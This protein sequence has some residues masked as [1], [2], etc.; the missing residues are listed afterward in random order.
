M[1]KRWTDLHYQFTHTD[2]P[3]PSPTVRAASA[4]AM[5]GRPLHDYANFQY[6]RKQPVSADASGHA[7]Y[8]NYN[9]T[10]AMLANSNSSTATSGSYSLPNLTSPTCPTHPKD[11][12]GYEQLR[13][14]MG[15]DFVFS[16]PEVVPKT[17]QEERDEVY[18]P[19]TPGLAPPKVKTSS[20]SP[21]LK[22]KAADYM[23]SLQKLQCP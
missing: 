6:P 17:R 22:K 11:R 12:Q 21:P 3:S 14:T 7:E 16:E 20:G 9:Q 5:D 1:A 2:M 15:D 13:Q 23:P 8:V 4:D 18:V 19:F 10:R